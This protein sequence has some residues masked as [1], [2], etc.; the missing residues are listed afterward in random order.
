MRPLIAKRLSV[1]IPKET[2]LRLLSTDQLCATELSC[3]D[4]PT[5][6]AL[7]RLCLESCMVPPGRPDKR[8]N[9]RKAVCRGP[10]LFSKNHRR[11]GVYSTF[12]GHLQALFTPKCRGG[13]YC[14]ESE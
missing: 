6:Y 7:R 14:G 1:S 8:L 4:R 9:D 12:K 11:T 3:L 5:Q 13:Q 10:A 2:L